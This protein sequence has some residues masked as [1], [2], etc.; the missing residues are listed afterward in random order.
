[1]SYVGFQGLDGSCSSRAVRPNPYKIM[2]NTILSG[3]EVFALLC[4]ICCHLLSVRSRGKYSLADRWLFRGLRIWMP[5]DRWVADCVQQQQQQR[6]AQQQTQRDHY[7][8]SRPRELSHDMEVREVMRGLDANRMDSGSV[9]SRAARRDDTRLLWQSL[10]MAVSWC[11]YGVVLMVT[12]SLYSHL[13]GGGSRTYGILS[14]CM[15][16]LSLRSWWILSLQTSQGP[17]GIKV[18]ILP[19]SFLFGLIGASLGWRMLRS[20]NYWRF[21]LELANAVLDQSVRWY[22]CVRLF[23]W[24]VQPTVFVPIVTF[25]L[26]W[27]FILSCGLMAFI[28][29]ESCCAVTNL[30]TLATDPQAK[31]FLPPTKD[32]EDDQDKQP[33]VPSGGTDG[34]IF[35]YVAILFPPVLLFCYALTWH[36]AA[37]PYLAY[38]SL[39]FVIALA[40]SAKPLI[41]SYMDSVVLTTVETLRSLRDY[42]QDG[43]NDDLGGRINYPFHGRLN[44]LL[45]QG[46]QVATLILLLV[47]CYTVQLLTQMGED[48]TD[49]KH[50]INVDTI[51][52]SHTLIGSLTEL[53]Q[54][55][56]LSPQCMEFAVG[57]NEVHAAECP[58][59]IMHVDDE[60]WIRVVD[61]MVAVASYSLFS[62]EYVNQLTH[63]IMLLVIGLLFLRTVLESIRR[64][65]SPSISGV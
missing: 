34:Q 10:D 46:G 56:I 57:A 52:P 55:L 62:N 19:S 61:A 24:K 43:I 4:S 18:G 40:L 26:D 27:S 49:Q 58:G 31:I 2:Q 60:A 13:H 6:Q 12:T 63:A 15:I 20:N 30:V 44:N 59:M 37:I 39:I 32:V 42:P 17:V 9:A 54:R 47:N 28:L 3:Q 8:R 36:D 29:A 53:Q 33:S 23:G 48:K 25:L 16:L 45:L 65:Q 1:M 41:Q 38:L 64:Y 14:R 11:V 35:L 50:Q 22:T 21:S 51:D 5:T 7:R